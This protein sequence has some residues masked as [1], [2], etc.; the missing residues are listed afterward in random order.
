M[1]RAV[2]GDDAAGPPRVLVRVDEFPYSSAFDEPE[3]YGMA[4]ATRFHELLV[5]AEIPYLMAVVPQLTR[6]HLDPTATGGRELE[7]EELELLRRMGGDGVVFAQHGTTHR[8]RHSAPY[9]RSELCGLGP[10][11]LGEL[12]E[13]GRAKLAAIGI[14]PRVFV[15]PFNRFDAGQW[16]VLAGRY[17]VV[18]G[19]PESVPLIG[20]LPSPMWWGEAVYVPTYAPLY[21]RSGTILTAMQQLVEAYEGCWLTIVLH[22]AWE[23]DDGFEG[24]ARLLDWIAPYVTSW[25]EF[26]AAV[27]RSRMDAALPDP[28]SV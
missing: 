10:R 13:L 8:T 7:A 5:A 24:L 12:L 15:P 18:T 21:G 11:G 22:T 2:L 9:R 1:R 17:A 3:R 20:A 27:G 4:S 19:G 28:L 16:P 26:L 23:A 14:E 6:Q 25:P